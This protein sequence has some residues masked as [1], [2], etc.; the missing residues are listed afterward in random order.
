MDYNTSYAGA[1]QQF[2]GD[3]NYQYPNGAYPYGYYNPNPAWGPTPVANGNPVKLSTHSILPPDQRKLMQND[4]TEKYKINPACY[5][6]MMCDH[7]NQDGSIAAVTDNLTKEAYCPIC[8]QTYHLM[9]GNDNVINETIDKLNRIWHTIKVLNVNE[10]DDVMQTVANAMTWVTYA[11]PP[12]YETVYKKWAE[13]LN[14]M[15]TPVAMPNY[16]QSGIPYA[17]GNTAAGISALSRYPAYTP[18]APAPV[19]QQYN[20]AAVAAAYPQPVPPQ[21]NP[22]G[23]AGMVPPPTYYQQPGVYQQQPPAYPQPGQPVPQM[24]A[25]PV[26][27][28]A[29]VQTVAQPV[30]VPQAAPAPTQPAVAQGVPAQFMAQPAPDPKLPANNGPIGV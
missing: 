30:Q 2:T 4:G 27:Q 7:K 6:A 3:P 25:P 23:N 22:F 1:P 16:A 26:Q 17:G 19:T 18:P 9:D 28:P 12:L 29:P 20:P 13:V 21:A 10:P 24:P 11:I 15:A 8:G 5:R 14:S